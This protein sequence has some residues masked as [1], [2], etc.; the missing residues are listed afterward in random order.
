MSAKTGRDIFEGK[1]TNG[2]IEDALEAAI[3]A[4]KQG[5][6]TDLVVWQLEKVSGENGGFVGV[7]DVTVSIHAQVPSAP[8]QYK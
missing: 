8:K 5:L 2:N 4:A 3:A 6:T 7:N 1:S